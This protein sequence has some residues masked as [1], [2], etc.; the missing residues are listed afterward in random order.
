MSQTVAEDYTYWFADNIGFRKLPRP[1]HGYC[2]TSVF[3]RYTHDPFILDTLNELPTLCHAIG[4]VSLL[5]L[6]DRVQ[7]LTVSCT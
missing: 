5:E 1:V 6:R 2:C 4:A 3:W 7:R